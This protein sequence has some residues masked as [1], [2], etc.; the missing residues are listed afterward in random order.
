MGLSPDEIRFLLKIV[1]ESKTIHGM[2]LERAVT[3]LSKLQ[4]MLKELEH[5]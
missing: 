5:V 2:D 3:A 1:I 4:K